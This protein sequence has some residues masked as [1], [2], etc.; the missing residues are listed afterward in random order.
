MRIKRAVRSTSSFFTQLGAAV[1]KTVVTSVVLGVVVVAVMRY[2]GVPV[3]TAHELMGGVR[4][5]AEILS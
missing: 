1:V 3:P 4:R 5:L 2:M